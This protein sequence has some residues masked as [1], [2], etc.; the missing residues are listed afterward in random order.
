MYVV[1]DVEFIDDVVIVFNVSSIW[2]KFKVC[3]GWYGLG[4]VGV[5]MLLCI[6]KIDFYFVWYCIFGEYLVVLLFFEFIVGCKF[7]DFV[8]VVGV[9]V[10]C[11][12]IDIVVVLW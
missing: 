5:V 1:G 4:F 12:L 10:V 11:I 8:K 6:I 9:V 7:I 3:Y 2:I